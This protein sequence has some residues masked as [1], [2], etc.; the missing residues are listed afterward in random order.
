MARWLSVPVDALR[1]HAQALTPSK[2]DGEA[3][4]LPGTTALLQQRP[5]HPLYDTLSEGLAT[6][7]LMEA[8]ELLDADA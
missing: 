8:R 4:D 7:D 1:R 6:P 2:Y 3:A 5:G